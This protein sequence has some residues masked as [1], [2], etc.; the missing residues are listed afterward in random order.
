MKYIAKKTIWWKTAYLSFP[1]GT[2]SKEENK[3]KKKSIWRN[4]DQIDNEEK[5]KQIVDLDDKD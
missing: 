3:P 5:A 1:T 4:I 2:A